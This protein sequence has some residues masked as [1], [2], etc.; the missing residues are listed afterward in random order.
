MYLPTGTIFIIL[1]VDQNIF[2][3]E[4]YN[5]YGFKV[6]TLIFNLSVFSSKLE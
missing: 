1:A 2:K 6:H 5:V 4:L 3:L